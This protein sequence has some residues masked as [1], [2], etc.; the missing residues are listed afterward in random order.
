MKKLNKKGALSNIVW[1]LIGIL[2]SVVL[3]AVIYS[4]MSSSMSR[5]AQLS[6]NGY[7]VGNSKVI[8]QIRDIGTGEVTIKSLELYD[9]SG[10]KVTCT[11][12]KASL[13]GQNVKL[14]ITIRPGQVLE[15]ELT[16]SCLN[17]YSILVFTNYG[18]YKGYIST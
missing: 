17:A 9:N 3:G 10:N 4:F 15:I 12:Q 14:P 2:A 13:N 1:A 8:V 5:N 7:L 6:V 16:G 18:V 11:I